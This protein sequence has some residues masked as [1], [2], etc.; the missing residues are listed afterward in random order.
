VFKRFSGKSPTQHR[1]AKRADRRH[2]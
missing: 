2:R 1:A